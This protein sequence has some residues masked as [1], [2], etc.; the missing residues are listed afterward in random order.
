MIARVSS[1]RTYPT[2]VSLR[3]MR[4]CSIRVSVPGADPGALVEHLRADASTRA[5]AARPD[6]RNRGILIL[7]LRYSAGVRDLLRR[8]LEAEQRLLRVIAD[9]RAGHA[10]PPLAIAWAATHREVPAASRPP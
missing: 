4:A 2:S 10:N 5:I 6:G 8:A 3:I 1:E 9:W 7:E